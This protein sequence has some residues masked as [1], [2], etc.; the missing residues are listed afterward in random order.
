DAGDPRRAHPRVEI[1]RDRVAAHCL[2]EA[3]GIARDVAERVPRG[4]DQRVCARASRVLQAPLVEHRRFLALSE[5]EGDRCGGAPDERALPFVVEPVPEVA[6]RLE[7]VARTAA[8]PELA[9]RLAERRTN[10]GLV[11]DVV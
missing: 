9:Q 11:A 3:T 7:M 4:R 5:L 6:G 8:V 2:E 1:V 10:H